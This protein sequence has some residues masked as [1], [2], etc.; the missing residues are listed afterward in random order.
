MQVNVLPFIQAYDQYER[1]VEEIDVNSFVLEI[2]S[3]AF[4]SITKDMNNY[5]LLDPDVNE[6][7]KVD[8]K[9]KI[10][11][12]LK[13]YSPSIKYDFVISKMV[14]EHI[15]EP[16]VFH[17]K[18]Q[19]LLKQEG[20]AIHFFACGYSLPSLINRLLPERASDFILR[21]IRNRDID[22]E[23]KYKAFYKWTDIFKGKVLDQFSALGF[24]ILKANVFIGHNYLHA[25]PFLNVIEKFYS[26]ISFKLK[27]KRISSVALLIL[28]AE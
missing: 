6:L 20:K 15:E 11:L 10:G 22:T 13:D 4:P 18:I 25:V 23:P 2:G 14:L 19:S 9:V 8:A 5:H 7:N 26:F 21:L 28:Q 16:E 24:N 12:P 1:L 3:G 17:K 27:F